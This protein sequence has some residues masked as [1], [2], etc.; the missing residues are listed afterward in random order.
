MFMAILLE[1]SEE[2]NHVC[3]VSVGTEVPLSVRFTSAMVVASF[4]IVT[5]V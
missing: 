1:M 4:L 5:D 3:R 2:E